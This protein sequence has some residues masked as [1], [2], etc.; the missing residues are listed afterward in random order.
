MAVGAGAADAPQSAKNTHVDVVLCAA[1]RCVS[2]PRDV[3]CAQRPT[4][5]LADYFVLAGVGDVLRPLEEA[6]KVINNDVGCGASSC[7]YDP[8]ST[9]FGGSVLHRYPVEEDYEDTPFPNG[10]VLFCFPN[11]VTLQR[12][13]PPDEPL[14]SFFT[15]VATGVG[16][17]HLYGHC[18]TFYERL[19]PQQEACLD[20]PQT[21]TIAAVA[22]AVAP[23]AA[24]VEDGIEVAVDE[25][26][27]M[28]RRRRDS[29]AN[30]NAPYF[31]PK[32]LAILSRWCFGGFREFLT[33]LYRMSLTRLSVPLERVIG[34][35]MT[36][37]A[38]PPAGRVAVQHIIG[39]H[40]IV[41]QRP[42][43]N[44]RLSPLGLEFQEVFECLDVENIILLFRCLLA[45]RQVR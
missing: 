41:F 34:N 20:I 6:D 43:A 1:T 35:F 27:S 3:L 16:G 8:A 29:R 21:T 9:I 7:K 32:C 18:L 24:A 10:V 38:L 36:E 42:P 33:E 40:L 14:P 22:P 39:A 45:E 23:A 30:R 28:H 15:F 17:E 44:R 13:T 5:R 26:G 25:D 4:D 2:S 11:G 12:P 37:V 19:T 31:A